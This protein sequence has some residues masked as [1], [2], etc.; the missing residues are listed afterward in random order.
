MVVF[1]VMVSVDLLGLKIVYVYDTVHA[2]NSQ[3][4][5]VAEQ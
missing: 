1:V 2:G 5:S 4:S 3:L